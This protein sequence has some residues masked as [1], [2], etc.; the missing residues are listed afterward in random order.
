M[1][2]SVH[3]MT[4]KEIEIDAKLSEEIST[5]KKMVHDKTGI[6]IEDQAIFFGGKKSADH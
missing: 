6:P 1:K 5:I 3:L 2:F 4:G